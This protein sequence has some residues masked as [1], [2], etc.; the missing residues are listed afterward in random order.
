MSA[1]GERKPDDPENQ[2]PP[3]PES[4]SSR[5]S[6]A[7]EDSSRQSEAKAESSRPTPAAG[8]SA[9]GATEGLPPRQPVQAR[10]NRQADDE[11]MHQK[12]LNQTAVLVRPHVVVRAKRQHDEIHHQKHAIP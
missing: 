9:S 1:G 8:D 3:N 6:E 11:H 7:Q 10:R 4:G 5:Q 12:P 2:T